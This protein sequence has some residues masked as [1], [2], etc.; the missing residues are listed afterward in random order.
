MSYTGFIGEIPLGARGLFG[1]KN[2]AAIPFDALIQALN[3][4]LENGTVQ[5]EGGAIKYNTT[6]ITGAPSILGGFDW[7]PTTTAQRMVVLTSAGNLLK[8]SGAGDFP[9]TLKSGLTV[10]GVVP[11]FVAGGRETISANRK[12]FIFT[13]SNAVQVL[14]AD[15]AT[16]T[17]LATP[18]ADW[19]TQQPITGVIHD[20]RLWAASRHR[21]Y[22]STPEN[23]E[24]FTSNGSGQLSVF[25]GDGEEIVAL[26]SFKGV[27]LVFKRPAGVYVVDTRNAS[28]VQLQVH[29]VTRAFGAAGPGALA[30]IDNDLLFAD[31]NAGLHV[32]SAVQ[33][34]G[35]VASSDITQIA[36]LLPFIRSEINLAE[37][38]IIRVA[39]YSAKR[40][41]HIAMPSLGST[42]NN[43]RLVID[44]NRRDLPRFHFSDRDNNV[45]LW[46]RKDT[47]NI[48]RLIHGDNAG[49]V[50]LMDQEGRSKN[51]TGYNGQ[52]QTAYMDFSHLDP[53]LGTIRKI[54]DFLELVVEPKGNWTVSIDVLWDGVYVHTIQFNM[55][56]TG[57]ALGTFVLGTDRLAGDQ[58]VNRRRRMMGSGRRLSLVF[59]NSGDAQ[60]FSIARAYVH[61]HLGD[62]REGRS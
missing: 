46:L 45:S 56:L 48:P 57:V 31:Q 53:K 37:F 12:L 22:F 18:P 58:I 36:D 4:T 34:Y 35:D 40:Q 43:R 62:E 17:D 21:I 5:K 39:Y 3:I 19:A 61:F 49:F 33:E 9:V 41:A 60:D 13:G 14:S 54:A 24:D 44:F 51:S 6:A 29:V 2:Q 26:A 50:Y 28:I 52:F 15:G 30:Q 20:Q 23:H 1:S 42:I 55:G 59:K 11:V 7:W 32:I 10:I 16:T 25:S 8:D 47:N 27:I 38:N